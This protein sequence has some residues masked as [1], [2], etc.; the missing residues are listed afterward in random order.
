MRGR[1]LGGPVC[2]WFLSPC[3][4]PGRRPGRPPDAAT[5]GE[6]MATSSSTVTAGGVRA[7]NFPSPLMKSRR[8]IAELASLFSLVS[9]SVAI[10]LPHVLDLISL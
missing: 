2:T 10:G 8:S 7:A 5:A 4:Q 6:F 9:R 3:P 1:R